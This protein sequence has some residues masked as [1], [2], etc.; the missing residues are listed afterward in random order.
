MTELGG[1]GHGR[2]RV[3]VHLDLD[4]FYAQVE[5][6]R[7]GIPAS[8]PVAVQQW[9]SLLAVNYVARKFGIKRSASVWW[10]IDV[11]WLALGL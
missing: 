11:V 8:E 6:R 3:I 10:Q 9:G 1:R 4:C 2:P 5:Q 7:L